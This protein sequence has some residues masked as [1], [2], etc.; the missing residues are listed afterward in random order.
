MKLKKAKPTSL[1]LFAGA[2][3]LTEGLH[4]AG[5]N[6]ILANEYDEMA[7]FTFRHN[8][9]D[10]PLLCRDIKEL[11]VK[12]ILKLTGLRKGE[13]SLV[14]GGPPCQGFSLA[15]PRLDNDPRNTMFKE[16][17]R[18][19]DGIRPEVFLFENVSGITSMSGGAVLK[20]IL[21]EF[22]S[23]GY[24]C[25]CRVLNAA[26]YGV[27]QARPRFILIGTRDVPHIGF[28]QKT[29][30]SPDVPS[31][32]FAK[33]FKPYVTTWDALSDLP[34]ISQG[35]GE[36]EMHFPQKATN[37][38]QMARR[39]HRSPGMLF[40]HR[41]TKHNDLIVARYAAI[42]EGGNNSQVPI[43]LRTKKINVFKLDSK[44]PA[45]TI[46]CNH[47]TDILHPKI[48]R[49]TTVREAARLQSF[50]DDY[51][52]FGNLTRKAKWLT[53]DDQVG[54]AVPPLLAKALGIH[55][56]KKMKW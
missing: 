47:R 55:I 5:F 10:V 13:I 18:I 20:A 16:F 44:K 1:D 49:G 39:G 37:E 7:A 12:E 35:E 15:G 2:G 3:G 34:K 8:H 32:L 27:P 45:R 43:E 42:P 46:T 33:E 9:P 56:K 17:V 29:H 23:I 31:D 40:N 54:N 38:Y 22:K 28:P 36:E 6:T 50:D 11:S 41:A 51:Q 25:D 30:T 4:Q 52:F 24:D 19:V 26:D 14:C 21:A 53:Q 48:P